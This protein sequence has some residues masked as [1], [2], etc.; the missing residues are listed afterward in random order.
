MEDVDDDD[1]DDDTDEDE[2]EDD[3][4]WEE[5]SGSEAEEALAELER[6]RAGGAEEM[7]EDGDYSSDEEDE[8]ARAMRSQALT[9]VETKAGP[10]SMAVSGE[11]VV[12][13]GRGGDDKV[14]GARELARYY[15][16]RPKPQDTRAAVVAA[17]GSSRERGL[18]LASN[19][20]FHQVPVATKESQKARRQ[21][22]RSQLAVNAMER[23]VAN[24]QLPR[25]V[26]Y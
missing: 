20:V 3:G 23:A 6:R 2:D 14:I 25:N 11:L 7:S 15:R 10:M 5:M 9:L 21:Y 13:A 22:V 4:E 16:Q 17:K 8:E 26:P 1:D 19:K 12:H 18:T 24:K